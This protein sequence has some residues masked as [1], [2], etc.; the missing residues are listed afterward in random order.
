MTEEAREQI[1]RDFE[2]KYEEYANAEITAEM[3][4]IMGE[5]FEERMNR[6]QVAQ[7]SAARRSL[8]AEYVDFALRKLAQSARESQEFRAVRSKRPPGAPSEA[9]WRAHRLTHWSFRD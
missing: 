9:E 5:S 7:D 3:E 6:K 1:R 2:Q 8:R 4:E